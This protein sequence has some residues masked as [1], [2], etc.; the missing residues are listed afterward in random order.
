[1]PGTAWLEA[2]RELLADCPMGKIT[3]AACERRVAIFKEPKNLERPYYSYQY[4]KCF[5]CP[6]SGLA[7]KSLDYRKIDMGEGGI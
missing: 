2:N 3:K 5:D 6:L 1:M 4:D 7:D